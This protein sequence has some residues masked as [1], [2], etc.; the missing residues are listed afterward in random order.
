M[1]NSPMRKLTNKKNNS[2]IRSKQT[3]EIESLKRIIEKGIWGPFAG[4]ALVERDVRIQKDQLIESQKL[5]IETLNKTIK[6]LKDE[7]MSN[8]ITDF[9]F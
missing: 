9:L 4:E 1:D 8:T 5:E 2:I 3:K 6:D 7:Y